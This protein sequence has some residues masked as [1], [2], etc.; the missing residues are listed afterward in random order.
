MSYIKR[1]PGIEFLRA[2]K[3]ELFP[4]GTIDG[5]VL[6]TNIAF[7]AAALGAGHVEI[8][9]EGGWWYVASELNWLTRGLPDNCAA[10]YL[11]REVVPF[12]ELSP[13]SY[14]PEIFVSVFADQA[15]FELDGQFKQLLGEPPPEPL[16][17]IGVVPPWCSYV[18]AFKF[19]SS[20]DV[21]H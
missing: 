7:G 1:P 21:T 3:D 14:R 17:H 12:P 20:S 5:S 6:V 19:D 4:N 13:N 15:Y 18:L 9:D 11:F 16:P 2:R 10:E 8:K